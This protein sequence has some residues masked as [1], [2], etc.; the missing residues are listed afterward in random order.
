MLNVKDATVLEGVVFA[1]RST[2]SDFTPVIRDLTE[3]ES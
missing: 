1:I 3:V 2:T